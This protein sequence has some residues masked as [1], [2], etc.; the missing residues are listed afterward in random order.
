MEKLTML[1]KSDGK[2][3]FKPDHHETVSESTRFVRLGSACRLTGHDA[4]GASP[5]GG[6]I[7]DYT[8]K[9]SIDDPDPQ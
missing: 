2:A 1:L 6:E 5:D 7:Q 3:S 4:N 9:M 8:Y